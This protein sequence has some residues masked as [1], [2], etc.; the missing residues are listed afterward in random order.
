M[1]PPRMKDIDDLWEA[2][3]G[4]RKEFRLVYIGVGIVLAVEFLV[5]LMKG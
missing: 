1:S 5:P 3:N 2:V 4:I